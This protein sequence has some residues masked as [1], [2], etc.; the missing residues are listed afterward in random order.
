MYIVFAGYVLMVLCFWQTLY[1]FY[2]LWNHVGADRASRY[3]HLLLATAY[4]HRAWGLHMNPRFYR[5]PGYWH[6]L[7]SDDTY[8]GTRD[9]LSGLSRDQE[10]LIIEGEDLAVAA[11]AET[12]RKKRSATSVRGQAT[13]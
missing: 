13:G 9:P 3:Y 5:K 11:A 12:S 8:T 10:E 1:G 2:E 4:N 6:Y 7:R